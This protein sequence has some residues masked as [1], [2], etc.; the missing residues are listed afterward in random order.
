MATPRTDTG[1]GDLIQLRRRLHG[2][3]ELGLDLPRT[4]RVLLEALDGLPLELRTGTA[5]TSITAVLRGTHPARP[6]EAPAVLLRADMDALPLREQTG[7][8]YAYEGDLMHACGHDLHM[9]MLVGAV[10][11]LCERREELAGDVVFMFQPGEEGH[12]GAALMV[13]EGVLEAAGPRVSAAYALHVWSSLE[14][15][16]TF[17]TKPGTIMSASDELDVTITGRGGH[18]SAPH[19][20]ADPVS[21]MAEMITALQVMIGRSIDVLD[22]AVI[23]IGT[24]RAGG[25]ARNVIPEQA[26]FAATVRSFSEAT[27]QRLFE[28]IPRT[29]E[30][31]AA[32][33]GVNV[34][35]DLRPQYPPT[36]NDDAEN[37]FVADVIDDLFEPG[38]QARWDHSLV[39][40]E[41]F[42]R[43][44]ELVPGAFIGLS[45][46]PPDA[47]PATAPFNHSA[48]AVY[49]DA[50]I[51]DGAA[52]FTELAVR[53]LARGKDLT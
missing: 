12:D 38:R 52:L 49:D 31:V 50:V 7:L 2:C 45:A 24:V 29:L 41:D 36:V 4:Q 27:H 17:C 48:Y 28:L 19:R 51:A 53:R 14:P 46:V 25:G 26:T 40:S 1:S 37:A 5:L 44:L 3:P 47:D 32:A 23:S 10:R 42:S 22:P 18:G 13:D 9:S 35:V 39:A 16:G 8:E 21:A 33:H 15:H 43:V 34:E 20:A 6:K 11:A 30:G